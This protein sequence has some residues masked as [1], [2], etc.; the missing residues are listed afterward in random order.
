MTDF[1]IEIQLNF[2][3]QYPPKVYALGEK[4]QQKIYK[5]MSR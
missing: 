4:S 5:K 2:V 1:E 3:I